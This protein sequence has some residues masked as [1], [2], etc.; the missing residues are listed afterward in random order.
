MRREIKSLARTSNDIHAWNA[1]TIYER[2]AN[3]R[4]DEWTENPDVCESLFGKVKISLQ[5]LH[6][7]QHDFSRPLPAT[8]RINDE[9]SFD[10]S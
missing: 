8:I 5:Q 6:K 7:Y 4:G 10:V 9:Y 2:N 1:I 3:K